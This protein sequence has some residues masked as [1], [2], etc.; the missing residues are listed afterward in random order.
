[1]DKTSKKIIKYLKGRPG[2]EV[3][4][5]K[6]PYKELDMEREEFFSCIR[7]LEKKGLVEYITNQDNIHLGVSLS[8]AAIH[9]KSIKWD[10][11]KQ[12]FFCTYLGGVITGITS[13]L[14]VELILFLGAKL[15]QLI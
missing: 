3:L 7:H 8:H 5:H 2:K 14:L 1:M 11:F 9:Q 12:W 10:S 15:V 4:Y 13:T 6:E